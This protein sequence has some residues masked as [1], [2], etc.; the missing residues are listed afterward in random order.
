MKAAEGPGWAP[1]EL[2]FFYGIFPCDATSHNVWVFWE[3]WLLVRVGLR[4]G[5]SSYKSWFHDMHAAEQESGV[6]PPL[7]GFSDRKD[8]EI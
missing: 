6:I 2:D 1:I 4:C 3:F 5:S 7:R 8:G